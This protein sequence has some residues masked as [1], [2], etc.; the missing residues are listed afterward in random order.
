MRLTQKA[1]EERTVNNET[2]FN[3]SWCCCSGGSWTFGCSWDETFMEN[4]FLDRVA[5]RFGAARRI[6]A[7]QSIHNHQLERCTC[8]KGRQIKAKCLKHN[9]MQD[10]Y[11]VHSVYWIV[12]W[13]DAS[14]KTPASFVYAHTVA[15]IRYL[16][17]WL[18]A[19]LLFS[20]DPQMYT[21]YSPLTCPI[22]THLMF[23]PVTWS[24]CVYV[25]R[26]RHVCLLI[27]LQAFRISL[28]PY[29]PYKR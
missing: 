8:P 25:P 3:A 13:D 21:P 24:F 16:Y 23:V 4:V 6:C 17:C 26:N 11:P 14:W 5:Y 27:I 20:P 22:W 10:T 7:L 29:K 2:Y 12:W 15:P 28:V 18:Y 9:T 1:H 19:P